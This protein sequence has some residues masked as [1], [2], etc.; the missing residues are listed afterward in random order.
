MDK[1]TE[2][3]AGD[4]N[5]NISPA[6]T[7]SF[8]TRNYF[9]TWNN[10][11]EDYN[12]KMTNFFKER[13]GKFIFQLEEGEKN[14]T[15][16]VQGIVCFKNEIKSVVLMKEFKGI[17]LMKTQKLKNA[18]TYVSKLKTRIE[19]PFIHGF[20]ICIPEPI[21]LKPYQ[22]FIESILNTK[23]SNDRLIHWFVD[24][25][26]GC[27]KTTFLRNCFITRDDIAYFNNGKKSDIAYGIKTCKNFNNL[28]NIV[29]NLTRT[30]EH[31]I[32]YE[33][34]EML[35]DGIIFSGKYE[36]STLVF[37]YC[38]III[39]SNFEPNV[40]SMSLDRWKIYEIINDVQTEI[41][42]SVLD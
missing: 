38:N 18:M 26:G 24:Y 41:K 21:V 30:T 13:D 8:K 42:P 1:N 2:N 3:P 22:I 37:N 33:A 19:G 4:G 32:N 39:L 28:N 27:G 20:N 34:I 16:H 23:G 7:N 31:S 36:S 6:D 10:P 40:Q 25:K 9:F 5:T 29:F 17:H 11:T 35:K 12:T 15:K 14:Q